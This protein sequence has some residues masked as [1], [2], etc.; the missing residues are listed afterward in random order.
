MNIAKLPELV[1]RPPYSEA[2]AA[3]VQRWPPPWRRDPFPPTWGIYLHL[4]VIFN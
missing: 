2:T 1:N 3:R 4:S